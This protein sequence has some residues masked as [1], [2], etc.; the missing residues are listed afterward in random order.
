MSRSILSYASTKFHFRWNLDTHTSVS[1]A[2][3]HIKYWPKVRFS[4][5]QECQQNVRFSCLS[6][7]NSGLWHLYQVSHIL[8][9]H[10]VDFFKFGCLKL[11]E[12][13][14]QLH[15]EG[16]SASTFDVGQHYCIVQSSLTQII[17]W[18]LDRL[19]NSERTRTWEPGHGTANESTSCYSKIGEAFRKTSLYWA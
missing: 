7:S 14:K 6:N 13:S 2:E 1:D 5:M 10:R 12:P 9:V 4:K 15:W 17:L 16:N 3:K 11:A 8:D 19:W 18:K